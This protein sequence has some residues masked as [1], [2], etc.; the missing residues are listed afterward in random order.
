MLEAFTPTRPQRRLLFRLS[1]LDDVGIACACLVPHRSG[2]FSWQ[3]T[4]EPLLQRGLVEKHEIEIPVPGELEPT[5]DSYIRLTLAGTVIA[6]EI[7]ADLAAGIP[8]E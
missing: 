4:I 7:E 1:L 5:H 8:I 2:G 3:H 6:A